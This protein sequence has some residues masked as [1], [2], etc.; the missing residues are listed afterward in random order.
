[1]RVENTRE[2]RAQ[3]R[4][5]PECLNIAYSIPSLGIRFSRLKVAFVLVL[6][7]FLCREVHNES[8]LPFV[9]ACH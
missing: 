3:I 8:S 4:S 9:A 1:M 6:F 7:V 5:A 2:G